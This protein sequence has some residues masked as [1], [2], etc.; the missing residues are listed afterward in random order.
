VSDK[1]AEELLFETKLGTTVRQKKKSS[2]ERTK[3]EES[4]LSQLLEA[5]KY[6]Q[7]QIDEVN[8]QEPKDK[9]A[10][11]KTMALST[12]LLSQAVELDNKIEELGGGEANTQGSNQKSIDIC[13]AFPNGNSATVS[14]SLSHSIDQVLECC[15]AKYRKMASEAAS[16]KSSEFVLHFEGWWVDEWLV[17]VGGWGDDLLSL[18]SREAE[19]EER[20]R[21]ERVRESSRESVCVSV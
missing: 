8:T 21:K 9:R 7:Q 11:R 13:C 2:A 3:E 4:G 12:R 14:C 18:V 10:R 6:L 20:R 19:G 15:L 16:K 5:R 17:W 1:S